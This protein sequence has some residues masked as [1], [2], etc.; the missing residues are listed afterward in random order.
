VSCPHLRRGAGRIQ[1]QVRGSS[2]SEALPDWIGV[3]VNA[4]A[5]IDGVPA[6]VVCDNLKAGV[7]AT[8][9]YEPGINRSYQELATP[10]S[11]YA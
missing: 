7:T 1:L 11:G 10:R 6:A 9:R 3:H 5:A 2:L 4:L 8:C